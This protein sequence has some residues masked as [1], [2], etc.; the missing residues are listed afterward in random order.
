MELVDLFIEMLQKRGIAHSQVLLLTIELGIEYGKQPFSR[1]DGWVMA[2]RHIGT[3]RSQLT[4]LK[5]GVQIYPRHHDN[6]DEGSQDDPPKDRYAHEG[7][8]SQ[9]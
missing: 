4:Q 7:S 2:S 8:L 1:F 5:Q 9:P 6:N 3:Q